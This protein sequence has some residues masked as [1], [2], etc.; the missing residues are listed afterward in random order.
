MKIKRKLE[1]IF[2]KNF[3]LKNVK[4]TEEDDEEINWKTSHNLNSKS[5]NKNAVRSNSAFISKVKKKKEC[6]NLKIIL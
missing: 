3:F 1:V 6:N 5:I 2:T 4:V